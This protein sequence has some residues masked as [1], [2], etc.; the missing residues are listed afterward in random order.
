MLFRSLYSNQLTGNVPLSWAQRM[1]SLDLFAAWDNMLRGSIPSGWRAAKLVLSNNGFT[2][3]P[4]TLS[5]SVNSLHVSA[6]PLNTSIVPCYPFLK[7]L[8]VERCAGVTSLNDTCEYA[9]LNR[10]GISETGFDAL[11]W[12]ISSILPSLIFL[13]EIGRAHV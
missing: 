1:E 9:N 3:L 11:P 10:L 13:S 12:N 8:F 4:A 5:S 7:E 6:N 2:S